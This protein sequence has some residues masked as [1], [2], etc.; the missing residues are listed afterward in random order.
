MLVGLIS[1]HRPGRDAPHRVRGQ[2]KSMAGACTR[3][4]VACIRRKAR[5]GHC[6]WP[7]H[8]WRLVEP[9]RK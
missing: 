9:L 4:W 7:G 2:H 5:L 8:N 6:V 1:R 3:T